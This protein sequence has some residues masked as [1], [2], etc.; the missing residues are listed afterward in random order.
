MSCEIEMPN[1]QVFFELPAKINGQRQGQRIS[2][3]LFIRLST[4]YTDYTDNKN[5]LLEDYTD[6]LRYT[7]KIAFAGV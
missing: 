3:I 7:E 6:D 1:L 4:D 2:N 5:R